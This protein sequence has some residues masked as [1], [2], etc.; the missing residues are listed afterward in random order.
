MNTPLLQT[1]F[2]MISRSLLLSLFLFSILQVKAQNWTGAI[3][4]DWNNAGNWT[5]WPLNG[6]DVTI[7]PALYTG[8][9]ASPEITTVSVFSPDRMYVMNGAELVIEASLTVGNRLI[10]SDA[11][12]VEHGA[13]TLTTDRLVMEL[14]G[15]Y[16]LTNGVVN[17]LSVLAFGDD[18]TQPSAFVQNGGTVTA[19]GEFGFDLAVGLSAPRYELNVGTLTVN[20]DALWFAVAPG[21]G[22]G[23]LVVNG[24]AATINGSLANTVGS[25]VDMRV[26]LNAGTLTTNGP[27]ITLAHTTDSIVLHGGAF[28][29]DGNVVVGND[30][31]V[32]ATAG[33]VSFDQQAELRGTGSYRFHHVSIATGADLQHTDPAEIAVAGDWISL[34]TFDPDVN[35]VAF[36]GG[37][38]QTVSSTGFF[39][40]R[41]DNSGGGVNLVGPSTVGG[42]L[43]LDN[44]IIHTQSNDLLT[45]LD[46]AT[47][48]SG[49]ASSHVDGPMKKIGN[50]A[51]VFPVGKNGTWRRIGIQDINDQDTEYTA[52]FIPVAAPAL[53]PLALGL[54]AIN[55]AEHWA[56]TRAVTADNA[57]VALYWEDAAGSGLTDCASLVV[58]RWDGTAWQG[59]PSTV[60]GSC[61]GNAAGNVE[62]NNS[63][64]SYSAF[65]FGT[66]DG[67]VGL[68]EADAA[69][70]FTLAPNPARDRVVVMTPIGTGTLPFTLNDAIGRVV[71]R[72]T[73]NSAA[74]TVDVSGL[75]NGTYNLRTSEGRAAPLIIQH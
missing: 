12:Q 5:D 75:P 39:G 10:V 62:S 2:N 69:S 35:S 23:H 37:A 70:A 44:G 31:V 26:E 24:G 61:V 54:S 32:H 55:T 22:S 51:F 53:T 64:S 21:T 13:G 6:E 52:E 3:N 11:S 33:Y 9:Q 27:G 16:T 46:N 71:L 67:T 56:L 59:E 15:T 40:L 7:D 38:V 58:A 65:T 36:V 25:T 68:A 18:G 57:R 19:N 42:A 41:L 66:N 60:S 8:A 50:D 63:V 4:S 1:L 14:G 73:L 74:N 72:G 29:V 45:V 47:A 48:T 28:H 34:G 49:S 20:G 30:G 43:V 17:T